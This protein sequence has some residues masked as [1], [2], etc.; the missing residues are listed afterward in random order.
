MKTLPTTCFIMLSCY[1]QV[2]AQ[3]THILHYTETSGYDHQTR[4]QSYNMFSQMGVQ[5]GFVVDN[6]S[7]GDA[8]NILVNL[9]QYD[10]IIFSNTT[11]N[12]IL[13]SVQQ[14]N[15]MQY[16]DYGGNFIG[17]H[18]ATD[19]YRHSTA[20]GTNTGTWD[21]FAELLGGSVRVNPS[22]VNG[23]P[24]YNLYAQSAHPLLNNI[25]D[26]WYKAEEYYYW[27]DGYLNPANIVLQEVEQTTGPNGQV[28]SYDSSRAIT[29]YRELPAGQRVFYT[30]LGHD[31]S[32]YTSDTTFYKLLENAVLWAGDSGTGV[33]EHHHENQIIVF[34][35]PFYSEFGISCVETGIPMEIELYDLQ[36]RNVISDIALCNQPISTDHLEFGSYFLTIKSNTA[37]RT[38]MLVKSF[39]R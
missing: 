12:G 30:A 36:G 6:D 1:L 16:I 31:V 24:S 4:Q 2:S 9:Q 39:E 13:D 17:I 28:N 20:N 34:P 35:N 29:W 32:N 8:F 25:P 27:E 3:L 19:T 18:S 5:N 14:Q 11:G 37:K 22:H 26:P 21:W 10:V 7:T 23:T 33:D 15:F 38:F